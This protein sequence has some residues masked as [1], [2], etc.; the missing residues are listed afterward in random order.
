LSI[1][2]KDDP[3]R[4]VFSVKEGEA[5]NASLLDMGNRFRLLVN[6]VTAVKPQDTPNLPV[7]KALWTPHPDLETSAKAWIY[8]GGAHHTGFSFAVKPRH[9][10]MFAEMAGME[11]LLIDQDTTVRDF[12][13]ELRWNDVSFS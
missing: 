9:L 7:A 4:L 5:L 2:G 1:G 8:A 3:A 11:Y 6:T 13:N 12:K 10:E